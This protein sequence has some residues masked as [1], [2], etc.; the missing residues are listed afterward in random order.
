MQ[1]G[2]FAK[3][4]AGSDPDA[5][6]GAVKEAGFVA[7]QYNWSCSGLASVPEQ[8]PDGLA[9]DVTVA[10]KAHGLSMA[11]VSGTVN[12]VHPDPEVCQAGIEALTNVIR[13]APSIGAPVV[14]LCTGSRNADNQWAAHPDNQSSQAWADLL[15]AMERLVPV[16]EEAGVQLGVEPELANVVNSAAAA[17]RLIDTLGSKA[18]AVV[19][20]PA[21]LFEVASLDE[22]Q[23][24]IGEALERLAGDI[25]IAHA[26]DR[27]EDGT[28]VPAGQGVLDY[29]F[30]LKRLKAVGFNGPLITHGLEADEAPGVAA[31][32][33]EQ[34]A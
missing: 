31:F 13:T 3:T 9:E 1:I 33:R 30:F 25:V 12:L 15:H 17:R 28:F 4:F 21:N 24:I 7:T 27:T 34:L 8:V 2:I 16:A 18:V 29:A 5:V 20:D 32:L 14:T 22:Q 19:F 26:K 23:H 11:A 10:T 6:L